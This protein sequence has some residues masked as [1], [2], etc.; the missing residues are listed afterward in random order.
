MVEMIPQDLMDVMKA[1]GAVA[2]GATPGIADP[3]PPT[4]EGDPAAPPAEEPAQT[5]ID[6]SKDFNG[7][8][9]T[10]QELESVTTR[11]DQFKDIKDEDLVILKDLKKAQAD[12]SKIQQDQ[13]AARAEL[14]TDPVYYKLQQVEQTNPKLKD[15]M[16]RHLLGGV[17]DEELV[18]LSLVEENPI[19][20]GDANDLDRVFRRRF[21]ILHDPEADQ[22]SDEYKD[23]LLDLKMEAGKT[24]TRLDEVAAGI[25]VPTLESLN[26]QQEQAAQALAQKWKPVVDTSVTDKFSV[27]IPDGTVLGE[28]QIPTEDL[29]R[30]VETAS[31]LALQSG[32]E[33]T[34]TASQDFTRAIQTQFVS[35]HW[36]NL[37]LLGINKVAGAVG[38]DWRKAVHNPSAG[39]APPPPAG[40]TDS[41]IADVDKYLRS[42]GL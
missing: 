25:E 15:L 38:Q 36:Q 42:Q 9:K 29:R 18:R 3:T 37:V 21:G 41:P 22:E 12:L 33:P 31:R 39:D 1:A 26:A 7:R 14:L 32:R 10:K 30:Y 34:E 5:V 16:R 23:A 4:P 24:R 40:N 28:V 2:E 6:L 11:L 8:F 19:L 27:T 35:E 13:A 17:S 20:G